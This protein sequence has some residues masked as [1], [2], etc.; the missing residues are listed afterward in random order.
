VKVDDYQAARHVIELYV[1]GDSVYAV[2]CMLSFETHESIA[3]HTGVR[4]AHSNVHMC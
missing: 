2:P 3:L 4:A 1:H